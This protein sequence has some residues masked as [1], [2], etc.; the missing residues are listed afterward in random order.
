MTI[1]LPCESNAETALIRQAIT[2][3]G[4]VL[5]EQ[6]IDLREY[7]PA[8]EEGVG[9]GWGAVHRTAS[10]MHAGSVTHMS[11]RMARAIREAVANLYERHTDPAARRLA[12]VL[13]VR[14]DSL[15]APSPDG[16]ICPNMPFGHDWKGDTVCQACGAT[17]T[18]ADALVSLLSG[19]RGFS[20]ERAAALVARHAAEATA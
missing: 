17:R 14:I 16:G 1:S 5:V 15:T 4:R 11:L 9:F 18:V 20:K 8:N 7:A 12:G 19:V 13:L 3:F 6:G 10:D 2:R